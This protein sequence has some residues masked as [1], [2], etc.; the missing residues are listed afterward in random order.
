MPKEM[1]FL[2]FIKKHD[3]PTIFWPDLA[4]IHYPKKSLEWFEQDDIELVS[5]KA[6]PPSCFE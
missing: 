1:P 6:N 3:M 4:T 2:P 5:K